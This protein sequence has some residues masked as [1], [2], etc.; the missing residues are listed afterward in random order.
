MIAPPPAISESPVVLSPGNEQEL[1]A[2]C[3]MVDHAGTHGCT[4]AFAW[5]N[6]P[7]LQQQ[8][9]LEARRRLTGRSVAEITLDSAVQSGVVEQW[10][11]F[12]GDRRPAVLFVYGIEKLLDLESGYT[13][14]MAVLNLN[15]G[16]I[17][18]R[19]PFPIVFW[20]ADFAMVAFSKQAPDAW[21][22][23]SESFH[24]TGESSDTIE[25]LGRLGEGEFWSSGRREKL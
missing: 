20:A 12:L 22:V 21:S 19:F 7:T 4:L 3:R 11:G 8:L 9:T 2:L 15:R 1:Q 18:R 10:E 25:T 6:H 23:K 24:F 5:V 16:Y 14:A 17:A 13:H